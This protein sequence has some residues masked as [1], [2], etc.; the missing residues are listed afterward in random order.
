MIYIANITD[1]YKYVIAISVIYEVTV[2]K[3]KLLSYSGLKISK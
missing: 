2:N 1:N 3:T